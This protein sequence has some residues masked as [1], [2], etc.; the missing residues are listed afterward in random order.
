MLPRMMPSAK[1][2]YFKDRVNYWARFFGVSKTIDVS[3]KFSEGTEDPSDAAEVDLDH[4][5]YLRATISAH[6]GLMSIERGFRKTADAA[7]CHE[8]LHLVQ[9]PL[10]SYCENMFSGDEGKKAELEKLEEMVVTTLQ[11]ALVGAIEEK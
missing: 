7:A 1:R 6:P 9:H 3:V 2:K 8:V 11:N 5:Q 4:M 10:I